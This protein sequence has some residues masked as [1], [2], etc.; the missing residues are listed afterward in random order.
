MY[1]VGLLIAFFLGSAAMLCFFRYIVFGDDSEERLARGRPQPRP[2]A[3]PQ[4]PRRRAKLTDNRA[5]V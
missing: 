1:F 5:A 3:L 2:R 4:K